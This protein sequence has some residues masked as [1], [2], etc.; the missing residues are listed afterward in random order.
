MQQDRTRALTKLF[1]RHRLIL[2]DG[3]CPLC[4]GFV[5]FVFARDRAARFRFV[6][7][8]SALGQAI[9]AHFGQPL[10]DWES[11]VLV[12]DGRPYFKSRAFFRILRGLPPPWPWLAAAE[13]SPRAL[14]DLLYDRI[15]RN[16]YALFGRSDRCMA[17]PADMASRFL[18]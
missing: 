3:A 14:N 11:N 18:A 7:V 13:A 4:S 1:Q 15:A 8:Q 5:G 17:P 2:F 9:L 12:E 6:A 16:R 10:T